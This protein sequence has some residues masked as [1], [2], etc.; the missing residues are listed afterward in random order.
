MQQ[1][2]VIGILLGDATGIGPEI[3]AKLLL[4]EELYAAARI[5][6]IG[7][8]RIFK[9]GQQVISA[10]FPF[11]V[12]NQ[13]DEAAS[14]SNQP[15]VLDF[16]ALSPAEVTY[17]Q[18]SAK[19]G[20]AV[21]ETLE[22]AIKLA[23]AKKIDAIVFAPLHKEAMGLGGCPYHAEIELFKD[24]FARPRVHG[25]INVLEN[26]WTTRVT[27]HVPLKEVSSLIT[28][29]RVFETIDLLNDQL[30]RFGISSPRI[31][32]T[33]LNPHAGENGTCGR[34]ELDII[35]PAILQAKSAKINVDGPFPA[36]TIFLRVRREGYHGVVSMYHDQGQIATKLLGFDK[37]VTLHGGMPI[38][39]TTPAHG[40]AFGRAG[41]GRANPDA[42]IRAYLIACQ[43][44]ENN[45]KRRL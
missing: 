32:V 30:I 38:P 29:D 20:K 3:V 26:L 36:D 24:R 12:V 43:L 27:S 4:K 19:A 15:V 14:D 31:A 5:V 33:A 35:A 41:E 6:V 7:D 25:E 21:Y 2:P 13:I 9:M 10:D 37:G 11:S 34:E 44:A 1:K 28:Q 22:F 39:I 18:V 23:L 16:P 17:K 42:M 40:T 45:L 8:Q